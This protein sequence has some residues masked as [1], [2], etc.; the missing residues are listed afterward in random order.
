VYVTGAGFANASFGIPDIGLVTASELVEH[1]RRIANAVSIPIVVDADTG[2]GGVLNVRRTVRELELPGVVA[3]QIEDQ[4][5]PKRCGHFDGQT[6][7]PI[8][9]MRQRLAAAVDA[10]TDPNL[11]I[12]ARTDACNVEGL[13]SAI[14]RAHAY[15][16][17]GADALFI[18]APTSK[19]D[20]LRLPGLFDAPLIANMVEGGKTP[21]LSMAELKDAGFRVALY[22][23]TTLRS[24]AFAVR[25]A[26]KVLRETGD[27]S[28]LLDRML[29]WSDR[30]SLMGL[31]ELQDL[32]DRLLASDP[33][34]SLPSVP[35]RRET[36]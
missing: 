23:N 5:M 14:A 6:V 25:R 4:V 13:E 18:E 19:D 26:L 21:L 29:S 10:R 3:I 17:A 15:L 28:A 35:T 8:G 24:A 1:V 32:E 31:T 2:F 22:A 12:I 36:P 34:P 7:V 27:S 30:Q 20:M 33:S 16:E 9:E 11:V